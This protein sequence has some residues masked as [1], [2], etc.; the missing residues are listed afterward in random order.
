MEN[1]IPSG[2]IQKI[3]PICR[4]QHFLKCMKNMKNLHQD[5]LYSYQLG[6]FHNIVI[7]MMIIKKQFASHFENPCYLGVIN[8]NHYCLLQNR[9]MFITF[10]ELSVTKQDSECPK[11]TFLPP[12]S[13]VFMSICSSIFMK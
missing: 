8:R 9:Q 6:Y 10:N 5:V 4:T 13:S 2:Q 3:N 1:F 7:M 12:R 11:E